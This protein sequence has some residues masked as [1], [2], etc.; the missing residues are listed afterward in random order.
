MRSAS[1]RAIEPLFLRVRLLA[2]P[3][4]KT[5]ISYKDS[6]PSPM[7]AALYRVG[8][9][10]SASLARPPAQN[11]SM[12]CRADPC[13]GLE[14]L[15]E[16]GMVVWPVGIALVAWGV[17]A[18][19]VLFTRSRHRVLGIRA[20][21]WTLGLLWGVLLAGFALLSHGRRVQAYAWALH[22][23]VGVLAAWRADHLRHAGLQRV[24]AW[25]GMSGVCWYAWQ[26][27]PQLGV[28][29]WMSS[30]QAQCGWAAHLVA[31]L[32]CD[33]ALWA[34]GLVGGGKIGTVY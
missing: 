31:C 26:F 17:G 23:S 18:L 34:A 15:V 25:L 32:A 1:G 14:P 5:L 27:G 8:V 28:A 22:A 12:E 6:S 21:L 29:G 7:M 20:C 16:A 4:H 30:G 11:V 10:V 19:P 2:G 24:A 3:T 9:I 13:K 33:V